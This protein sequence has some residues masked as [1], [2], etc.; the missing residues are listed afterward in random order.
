MIIKE[1]EI[2][3]VFEIELA[4][5]EDDRGSFMR[6]FDK[7]ILK[8]WGLDRDWVQENQSFNKTRGTVRGLHLQLHPCAETK[9]VR[10]VKGKIL[11][12]YLDLRKGSPTFGKWGSTILSSNNRKALFI[13]RGFGHG[14][15]TLS[16]NCF[17]V[18]KV[19][20]YYNPNSEVIIAWNDPDLG[21]NW[22]L[23]GIPL[24]SEKD[25]KAGSF[26]EFV[27]RHKWVEV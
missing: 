12:V 10:M 9:L 21:I 8:A 18:Y 17:M 22:P 16:D 23:E 6:T 27:K 4:P 25:S 14:M 19:D 20:N 13:P 11:D 24:L 15:C 1:R 7:K 2:K 26:K 3:G 5:H